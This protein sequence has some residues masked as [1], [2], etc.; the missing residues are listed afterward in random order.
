MDDYEPWRLFVAS[1]LDRQAELLIIGEATDGLEA[2]QI[3]EQL[4]PDLILL[5]I[6][7]PKLNG[8]EAARLIRQVSPESR[9]LFAS[10]NRSKEIVQ[11][12]LNTGAD[13]YVV[14]ANAASDLVPAM[15]AI[16]AGKGFVNTSL[17]GHDRTDASDSEPDTHRQRDE[18]ETTMPAQNMGDHRHHEVAFYSD[19]RHFLD[20]VG[21]FIEAALKAGNA[22]IVVAT[23]S[24]WKK[25]LSELQGY[26]TEVRAAI[27]EGRC[28]ALDA[29]ETL[30]LVMVNGV[31]DPNRFL[32]LFG[33]LL[34]TAREKAKHPHVSVFG[35]C[36]D[37]LWARGDA[38]AAVQVEKLSNELTK[39]HDVDI[40]CGY[41]LRI[42]QIM[43]QDI[44]Q[45]V[46]VEHSAVHSL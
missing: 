20:H 14:K 21:Q 34:M 45:R 46:C 39:I 17:Y 8:I 15:N 36:V 10:E 40:L 32:E 43:C 26:G 3:A 44:F 30:S 24:H 23:A 41:S 5:D 16:L 28:L 1:T 11:A 13:G 4:R 37:L 33:D 27:D 12:A 2:V 42:D 38:E 22:A 7:L 35:E 6:G 29:E 18:V 31:P 9:I 19:D 25:L